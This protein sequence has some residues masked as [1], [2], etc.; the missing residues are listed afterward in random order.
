M[1]L[2]INIFENWYNYINNVNS[3]NIA[4][5]TYHGTKGD[6]FDNV[7]I[8][9]EKDFGRSNLNF[10]G[11][12]LKKLSTPSTADDDKLKSARNLF[13]VAATRAKNNLAI[14]YTD[15]LDDVQKE[16]IKNAFGEIDETTFKGAQN[17]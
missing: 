13:Y 9:M 10:F 3:G 15:F 14:L 8:I 7:L 1:I 17:A 16:Q 11:N 5:H 12:L 6:E 2:N 4:Y